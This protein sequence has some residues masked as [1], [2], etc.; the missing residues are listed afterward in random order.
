ME[1]L[2]PLKTINFS[3]LFDII[4]SLDLNVLCPFLRLI[5]PNKVFLK[6]EPI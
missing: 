4:V 3:P 1:R 5:R 6:L 2:T